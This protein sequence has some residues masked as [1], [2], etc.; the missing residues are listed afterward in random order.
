MAY[1]DGSSARKMDDGPL[2]V[3]DVL[4]WGTPRPDKRRNHEERITLLC[5]WGQQFGL[6]GFVRMEPDLYVL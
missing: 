2:D 4:I 6:D 5:N 3:Q 1:F